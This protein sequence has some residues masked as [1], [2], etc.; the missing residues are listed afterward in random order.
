MKL[1]L[2][3]WI[4]HGLLSDVSEKDVLLVDG[5]KLCDKIE[6]AEQFWWYAV[7]WRANPTAESTPYLVFCSETTKFFSGLYGRASLM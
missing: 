5:Q 2:L 6:L 1:L 4:W 7:A 3:F